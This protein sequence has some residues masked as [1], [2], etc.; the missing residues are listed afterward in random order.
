MT[1]VY[2]AA[3]SLGLPAVSGGGDAGRAAVVVGA[4]G[5]SLSWQLLLAGL[6]AL[7]HRRLPARFQIAI[8]LLGNVLILVFAVAV[9]TGT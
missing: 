8:G 9:A 5:A 1:V 2:F 6:G 7:A 4:F 3:L